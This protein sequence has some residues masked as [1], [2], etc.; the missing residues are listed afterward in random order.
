MP[1]KL[2]V[3]FDNSVLSKDF[4]IKTRHNCLPL[5]PDCIQK[6]NRSVNSI[7][8]GD[9]PASVLKDLFIEDLLLE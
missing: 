7:K 8:R 5:R 1:A 3:S 9:S 2:F 4:W 6:K